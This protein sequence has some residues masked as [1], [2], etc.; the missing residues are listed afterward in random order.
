M[1]TTEEDLIIETAGAI[2]DCLE[3]DGEDVIGID[4]VGIKAILNG[5]VH[6]LR[7]GATSEKEALIQKIRDHDDS[8]TKFGDAMDAEANIDY[9]VDQQSESIAKALYYEGM[10]Q[11][12]SE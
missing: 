5:F 1:K 4:E 3:R 2:T 10:I 7:S 11:R 6:R 9:L 12:E 8:N